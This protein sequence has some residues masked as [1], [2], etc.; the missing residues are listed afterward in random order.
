MIVRDYYN[1]LVGLTIIV[2]AI[3][4]IMVPSAICGLLLVLNLTMIYLWSFKDISIK[5][6]YVLVLYRFIFFITFLT[7]SATYALQIPIV[8]Q[9]VNDSHLTIIGYG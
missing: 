9:N 1:S 8:K 4:T 7:F 2:S 5:Q 3:S 6:T